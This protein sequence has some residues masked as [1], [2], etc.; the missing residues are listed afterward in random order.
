MALKMLVILAVLWLVVAVS[1]GSTVFVNPGQ[2]GGCVN[3]TCPTLN[4]ALGENATANCSDRI[5]TGGVGSVF[6]GT[7]VMLEDGVHTLD[8][9]MWW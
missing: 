5:C 4:E 1:A 6:D 9:K 3:E 8:G 7:V 2:G